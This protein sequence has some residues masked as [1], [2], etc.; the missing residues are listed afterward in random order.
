[1]VAAAVYIAEPFFH[2]AFSSD[3]QPD[4]AQQGPASRGAA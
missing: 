3:E 2:I 4:T 1:M